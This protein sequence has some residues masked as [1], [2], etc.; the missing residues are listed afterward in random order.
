M[1]KKS[2]TLQFDEIQKRLE[3]VGMTVERHSKHKLFSSIVFHNNTTGHSHWTGTID[4]Y[5]YRNRTTS[6]VRVSVNGVSKWESDESPFEAFSK[7]M[8]GRFG[9]TTIGAVFGL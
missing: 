3:A 5:K 1:A 7:L 9:Q 4:A 8:R 2:L 6:N